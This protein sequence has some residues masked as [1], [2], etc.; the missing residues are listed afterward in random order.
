MAFGVKHS[1]QQWANPAVTDLRY[2]IKHGLPREQKYGPK[3]GLFTA[4]FSKDCSHI[5][6]S[7]GDKT[8][9]I[10]D[11]ESR[12]EVAKLYHPDGWPKCAIFSKDGTHVCTGNEDGVARIW[13]IEK[14][15]GEV[16]RQF[17]HTRAITWVDYSADERFLLT[18]CVDRRARV[19]RLVEE[20]VEEQEEEEMDELEKAMKEASQ[21]KFAFELE[22]TDEQVAQEL[23]QQGEVCKFTLR[24]TVFCG[25]FNNEGTRV[26]T[27]SG[28][29][30]YFGVAKVFDIETETELYS[31]EHDDIV[32]SVSFSADDRWL[33][34]ASRDKTARLYSVETG[35]LLRTWKHVNWVFSAGISDDAKL[36][37]TGCG[38]GYARVFDV[39]GKEEMAKFRH[40][41]QVFCTS[42]GIGG[43]QLLTSAND[44]A[45]RVFGTSV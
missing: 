37:C 12:K 43:T 22:K 26:C 24:D 41:D 6:T 1:N 16:V 40:P 19:W 4:H 38:D 20:E 42:F 36:F 2:C 31:F 27:A 3:F 25:R 35:D 8:S 13:N 17:E 15:D 21:E 45:F 34:T 18:S 11:A 10:F 7:G 14:F 30:R 32:T 28:A 29:T 33:V 44:G 23:Q 39:H 9:R 5:C